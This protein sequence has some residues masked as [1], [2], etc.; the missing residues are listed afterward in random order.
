MCKSYETI[1]LK[2]LQVSLLF[3]VPAE[4]VVEPQDETLAAGADVRI[5]CS[6][7]GY[8]TPTVTWHRKGK[9]CW[10]YTIFLIL[11]VTCFTI[12]SDT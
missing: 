7:Y 3:S 6:A 9:H 1:P 2:L 11:S 12:T 5:L 4:W 10:G 8:P